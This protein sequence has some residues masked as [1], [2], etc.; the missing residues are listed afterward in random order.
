MKLA[1]LYKKPEAGDIQLKNNRVD[2]DNADADNA[3][4]LA[5][6]NDKIGDAEK[7]LLAPEDTAVLTNL[8]INAS[9]TKYMC[10]NQNWDVKTVKKRLLKI[11]A[12][13][14]QLN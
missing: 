1:S 6:I 7:L 9:K 12:G 2:A 13:Q 8:Q 11:T 14:A 3:G 5:L 10:Y 4:D